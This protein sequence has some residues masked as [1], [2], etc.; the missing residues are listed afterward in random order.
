MVLASSLDGVK[1]LRTYS[2]IRNEQSV[3][4]ASFPR[5]PPSQRNARV[6]RIT[7]CGA[8][9]ELPGPAPP[10]VSSDNPRAEC[11]AER[12]AP[13]RDGARDTG[14]QE[15]GEQCVLS[16]PMVSDRSHIRLGQ[17]LGSV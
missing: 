15:L 14:S 12:G 1:I 16:V 9:W 7:W 5:N 6:F 11:A 2:K 17:V 13:G 3:E 10:S 4:A 8:G